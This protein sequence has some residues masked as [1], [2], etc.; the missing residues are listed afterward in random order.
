MTEGYLYEFMTQEQ[1]EIDENIRIQTLQNQVLEERLDELKNMYGTKAK[2]M[3]SFRD[4]LL[5]NDF[6]REEVMSLLIEQFY[7]MGGV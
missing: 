6:T 1:P 7:G 3:A 4:E 5:A 2:M